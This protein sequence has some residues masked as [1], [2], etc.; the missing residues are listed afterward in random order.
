MYKLFILV[1]VAGCLL[2]ATLMAKVEKVTL[3]GNIKGLGNEELI[4]LNSD[5]TEI[6]RTKTE[7]DHFKIMADLETGDYVIIRC[8]HLL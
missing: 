6:T 8:M 2:P 1:C 7:N 5:W 4:L 3:E